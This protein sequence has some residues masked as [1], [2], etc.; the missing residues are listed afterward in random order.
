MNPNPGEDC[1]LIRRFRGGVFTPGMA[2]MDTS[3][4]ERLDKHNVKFTVEE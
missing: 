4:I 1:Y 3:L 2:F